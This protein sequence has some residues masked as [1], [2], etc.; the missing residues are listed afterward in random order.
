[1]TL[2]SMLLRPVK[3]LEFRA[4]PVGQP[5]FSI[6]RDMGAFAG[7]GMQGGSNAG[8]KGGAITWR[9]T[10]ECAR[11]PDVRAP[12]CLDSLHRTAVTGL[13][14][15]NRGDYPAPLDVLLGVNSSAAAS[16]IEIDVGGSNMVIELGALANA[17]VRYSGNVEGADRPD[18]RASRPC[19]MD[20]LK[21]SNNTTH[22]KVQPKDGEVYNIRLVGAITLS[23]GTRLMYSESFA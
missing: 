12:G 11:P 22:P 9:G 17:V 4:R 18:Q 19:A 10:L 21:F 13:P 3:M 5:Q 8:E 15:I 7:G 16:R 14:I 1:M 2:P 20:M 6:R 23:A